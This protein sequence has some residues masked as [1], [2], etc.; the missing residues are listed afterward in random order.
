MGLDE[1][2]FQEKKNLHEEWKKCDPAAYDGMEIVGTLDN[3]P[4]GQQ[5]ILMLCVKDGTV[6]GC[7][8]GH[9][10]VLSSSLQEL[11]NEGPHFPTEE[12]DLPGK[13]DCKVCVFYCF[14]C[15]RLIVVHQV[16]IM[17]TS[18][19]CAPVSLHKR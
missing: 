2:E 18:S 15:H 8:D 3:T 9:P 16:W 14:K 5:L 6:H 1:T 10:Q 17:L 7:A 19:F 13:F 4:I 12:V 11:F